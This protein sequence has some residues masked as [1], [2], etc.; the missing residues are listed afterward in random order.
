MRELLRSTD[1]V[2]I[3]FVVSMLAS[4]GIDAVVLDMHTSI[5]EGSIAAIP[6]RIMVRE[7]DDARARRLLAE[8]GDIALSP[9]RPG[10]P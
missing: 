9:P 5:L 7:G 4:E 2:L 10:R 3:S 8:I 6:R 1:P